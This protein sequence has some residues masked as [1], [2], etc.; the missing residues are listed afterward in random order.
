MEFYTFLNDVSLTLLMNKK[1]TRAFYTYLWNAMHLFS[2]TKLV[3]GS[4][5]HLHK[6][7]WLNFLLLE[8][9]Q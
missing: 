7:K 5:E 4:I 9:L 1:E 2:N 8:H 3:N 6:L